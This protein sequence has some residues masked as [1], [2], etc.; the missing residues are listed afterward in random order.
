MT[1]SLTMK[2]HFKNPLYIP[3]K[4][5][6]TENINLMSLPIF[7]QGELLPDTFFTL[8]EETSKHVSQV[9]RM[10]EGE[11][12]Q[13]TNGK[14][15][16]ITAEIIT[17]HKKATEVKV[18]STSHIQHHTSNIT[19]AISLIKNNSRFEWFL[20]K[21]TEIG[22][23]EIIPLLCER[24]EKQHFRHD[25]MKNILISAMLQSQQAWLPTLHEPIKFK[26]IIKS[27]TYEKKYIAHCIEEE[28]KQLSNDAINPVQTGTGGQPSIILIGPE[29]D[30]TKEEIELAK[31]NN[32]IPVSLGNT[33]LR[34][35][36]A[37]VV[38]AV[39][40]NQQ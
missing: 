29:G 37:G 25:R 24:T 20:E 21:A 22:V 38:A 7:F 13:L 8:S 5:E 23:S 30:F 12:L 18:L 11:Q 32:F 2:H 26:E 39:L 27:S 16:I 34:T 31:Q 35:E 19:I 15:K 3:P 40:L 36:T 10:K 1:V 4:G 6:E 28:K 9:L 33:R 17:E 14:G